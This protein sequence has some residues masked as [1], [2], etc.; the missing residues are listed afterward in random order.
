MATGW[1]IDYIRHSMTFKRYES[2]KKSWKK[3]PPTHICLAAI[4]EMLGMKIGG[5]P[6][7]DT[8]KEIKKPQPDCYYD[9]DYYD[10]GLQKDALSALTGDFEKA[11]GGD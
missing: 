6:A 10:V 2:L 7:A 1:T 4:C 9:E 3:S 11:N 8:G 5:E